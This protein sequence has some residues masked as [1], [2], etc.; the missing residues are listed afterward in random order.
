[1]SKYKSTFTIYEYM[2]TDL[3]Y[4]LLL[5]HALLGKFASTVILNCLK[6]KTKRKNKQKMSAFNYFFFRAREVENGL[7]SMAAK[8]IEK[9]AT[10]TS[11][12]AYS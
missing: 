2:N 7:I 6:L 4:Q 3:L 8:R 12:A 10:G 1:M 9:K 5:I 11:Q